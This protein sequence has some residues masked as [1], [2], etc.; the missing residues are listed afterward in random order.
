MNPFIKRFIPLLVLAGLASLVQ[1]AVVFNWTGAQNIPDNDA[2]GVSFNFTSS[3]PATSVTDVSITLDI[4]GGYNSDLY[5]YLSRADGFAVLLNRAG[6][7]DANE[8]G[9]SN[10]GFAVTLSGSASTDLHLYQANSPSYNGN[11]QL[12]GLWAADGRDVDPE[13]SGAVFDGAARDASLSGF[14]GLNPNGNWTLFF[15]DVSSGGI[16]TLNSISV[17]I[18]AVPEPRETVVVLASLLLGMGWFRQQLRRR[19]KLPRTGVVQERLSHS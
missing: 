3:D 5:A 18:T 6:R 10:P 2:S 8:S 4:S 13:S 19:G 17:D 9:Y 11:G 1:A 12:A 15:A 16:S 7:T 14:N